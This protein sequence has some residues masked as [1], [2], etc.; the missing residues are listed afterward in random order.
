MVRETKDKMPSKLL[1]S[2]MNDPNFDED[3]V[4]NTLMAPIDFLL[5]LWGV[6]KVFK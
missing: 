5:D 3:E 2:V 4:D 1:L 6:N